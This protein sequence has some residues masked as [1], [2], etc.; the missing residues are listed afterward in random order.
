MQNLKTKSLRRLKCN[1]DKSKLKSFC[2]RRKDWDWIGR[3]GSAR[4]ESEKLRL[5]VGINLLNCEIFWTQIIL[6]GKRSAVT[7]VDLE[8]GRSGG[9]DLRGRPDSINSLCKEVGGGVGGG[10]S[11][12]NES[13][14]FGKLDSCLSHQSG[15]VKGR[16]R[17]SPAAGGKVAGWNAGRLWSNRLPSCLIDRMFRQVADEAALDDDAAHHFSSEMLSFYFQYRS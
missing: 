5:W 11:D 6:G 17:P 2:D 14:P 13:L 1:G 16:G 15:A 10:E 9:R 8:S 12:E 4:W 7:A 3:A